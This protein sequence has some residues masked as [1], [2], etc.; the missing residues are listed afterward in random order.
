MAAWSP[1]ARGLEARSYTG[2]D[3]KWVSVS[4]G[5]A[6]SGPVSDGRARGGVARE[7]GVFAMTH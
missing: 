4:V 2:K 1:A 5:Q 6:R 3:G 7:S